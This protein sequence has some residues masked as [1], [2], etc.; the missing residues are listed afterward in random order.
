MGVKLE[1]CQLHMATKDPLLLFLNY[2]VLF[3]FAPYPPSP[4]SLP[5]PAI[6]TA[7]P[8]PSKIV[9]HPFLTPFGDW[10]L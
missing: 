9:V 7:K 3:F 5:P 10:E 4:S 8:N 2:W 6:I 1:L